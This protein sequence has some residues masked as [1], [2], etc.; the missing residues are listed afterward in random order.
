[1]AFEDLQVLQLPFCPN[2]GEEVLANTAYCQFCG[3]MLGAK[4][5]LQIARGQ[6]KKRT[7]LRWVGIVIVVLF[8]LL[9]LGAAVRPRYQFQPQSTTSPSS[10]YSVVVTSVAL[11]TIDAPSGSSYYV[12]TVDAAYSGSGS[13]D[14]HPSDF[15][16][17]SNS[18]ATFHEIVM[19]DD[20]D[21]LQDVTIPNGQHDI[22]H[23]W[24]RLPNGQAPSKLE[25]VDSLSNVNVEVTGISQVTSWI[26]S[27]SFAEVKLQNP[28]N[29]SVFVYGTIQNRNT[30]Y[31][32]GD[33]ITAKIAITYIA[34]Q[35]VNPSS[36]IVTSITASDQG[37]SLSS[38]SP[39]PPVAIVGNGQE[40]DI[41]VG[42][43]V[44]SY[45]YSGNLHLLVTVSG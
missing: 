28:S 11:D 14:V 24:F 10:P 8:V 2:C 40:V 22:G 9:V 42:V 7:R 38:V 23:L 6:V 19:L 1:M 20:N 16:L 25:Y 12:L 41:T 4:P 15:Q 3:Y 17:V 35:G 13:W 26:S 27:I 34:V 5:S 45:C 33:T 18:S 39:S 30:F 36:I 29:L 44:P 21:L 37:F 43:V 31:Y 32:T